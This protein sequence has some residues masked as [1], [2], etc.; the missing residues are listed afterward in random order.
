MFNLM[1][2]DLKYYLFTYLLIYPII[3]CFW[4]LKTKNSDFL[5]VVFVQVML[6]GAVIVLPPVFAEQDEDIND[7]YTVLQILPLTKREI[8]GAKFLLPFFTAIVLY[9]SNLFIFSF[10]ENDAEVN[11]IVNL[12]QVLTIISCLFIIG[13]VY[14]IVAKIG[15]TNFLRF[16]SAGTVVLAFSFAFLSYIFKVDVNEFAE[17]SMKF[18]NELNTSISL[19]NSK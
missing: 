11:K 7:G 1:I 18:I 4:I 3:T 16:S 13:L 9:I 5:L 14:I 10:F 19:I 15:Y 8:M 12:I 2:K 17:T 6:L